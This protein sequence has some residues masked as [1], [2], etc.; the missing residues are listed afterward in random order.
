MTN[1]F[2]LR[3]VRKA[4]NVF[5]GIM[6]AVVVALAAKFIS[7]HYGAPVMLMALLIGMA[8][9]FLTEDDGKCLAGIE[10]SAKAFLR[11]GVALLGLGITLQRIAATG[12]EVLYITVGGVLL[13]IVCGLGLS[14]VLGRRV[15]FGL[16]TGGLSRSAGRQ[17][18]SPFR[19]SCQRM[20][21]WNG[22]RSSPSSP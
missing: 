1:S 8:F 7:E 2:G 16:L 11:I 21:C 3:A 19:R 13:T 20:K 22:I 10:F 6:M 4:Q 14:R 12:H 17:L 18:H 5:P 9:N 15:R